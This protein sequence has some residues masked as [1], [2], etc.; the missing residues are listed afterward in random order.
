MSPPTQEARIF[1][2][3]QATRSP[4]K[5]SV[6]HAVK[7]YEVSEATLRHRIKGRVAMGERCNSQFKLIPAEEETFVRYV[8]DLDTRGFPPRINAMKDMADLLHTM[9][10]AKPFGKQ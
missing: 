10:G 5:M 3:I 4:A 9:H 7:T 1:L 6:R 8:L 2:A